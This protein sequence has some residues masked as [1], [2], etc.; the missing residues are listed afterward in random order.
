MVN[1]ETIYAE[2]MAG[3]LIGKWQ[4]CSRKECVSQVV[5][6]KGRKG[7]HPAHTVAYALPGFASHPRAMVAE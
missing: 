5:E 6:H 1:G 3:V 7:E 4:Y 2:S